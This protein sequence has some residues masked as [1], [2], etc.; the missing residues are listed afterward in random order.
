MYNLLSSILEKLVIQK[1][2]KLM[3]MIVKTCCTKVVS[4]LII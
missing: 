3:K 4:D 1:K 2:S